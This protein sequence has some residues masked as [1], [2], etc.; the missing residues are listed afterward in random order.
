VKHYLL[1]TSHRGPD[2]PLDANR[3]RIELLRRVT[4]PTLAVQGTEWTWIVVVNTDDPLLIERLDAFRSAGS[5][6][7]PT[8]DIASVIDWS[9]PVLTTRI[10]D[11]DGFAPDAFQRLHRRLTNPPTEP[12]VLMFPFGYR[13]Y[14]GR[15]DTI[16]HR[17]NAWCSVYSPPGYRV[18]AKSVQHQRMHSLAPV[19]EVDTKPAWLWVRHPDTNS[20]IKHAE[21]PLIEKVRTMFPVD[22]DLIK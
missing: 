9:G 2:Y 12:R 20:G 15:Y 5:H 14:Q 17:K 7:I 11:D 10:D 19:V 22:W 16:R 4:V 3:R 8:R 6:V 1:T 13:T 21:R 18:H